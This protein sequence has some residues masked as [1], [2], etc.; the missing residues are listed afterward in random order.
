[1]L[2]YQG[3]I[4]VIVPTY[5]KQP[6]GD[7]LHLLEY[8]DRSPL[9]QSDVVDDRLENSFTNLQ[10]RMQQLQQTIIN[11]NTTKQYMKRETIDLIRGE[12]KRR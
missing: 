3:D 6:G 10:K 8:N 11:Q 1:M 12:M 4:A 9:A 7:F 5:F 2:K